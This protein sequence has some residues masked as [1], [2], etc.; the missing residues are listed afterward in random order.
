MSSAGESPLWPEPRRGRARVDVVGIGQSSLDHVCV[1][2]GLP[3]FAGKAAI[4]RYHRLP[5]GQVATALLAC[6]RLGLRAAFVG[7]V[8]DDDAA[9]AVLAPLRAGGV[10]LADVRVASEA[11]TQMAVILVDR[12]S[13]ERTVLW[14]RDRALA[15]QP[16]HLHRRS[17][18]GARLLHLDGGDPDAGT[19]AA[20]VA[21]EEGIPV[22]LDVDT[23]TPGLSELLPLV[24]FPIV[25]QSFAE[26]YF[27]TTSHRAALGA[28]VASGARM[29]VVT[30]GE[31]G[32]LAQAGETTYESP[33]FRVA[34]RDTTGAGDVFHAAFAWA[35]LGGMGPERALRVSN[36]AAAMSVRFLGAQGGLPTRPELEAFLAANRPAPWRGPSV[37]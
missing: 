5:G 36:A 20:R 17:I 31:I 14:H 33:G 13:G 16:A 29:A 32:A 19:W 1:V 35:V 26:T 37:A 27:G 2:D 10:D 3:R 34:V 23:P 9:E 18:S 30:L 6:A 24:D 22:T 8:G 4:E 28:L 15:I 21:R 11:P 12:T 7:A 25:S